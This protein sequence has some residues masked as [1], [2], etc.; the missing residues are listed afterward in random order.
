MAGIGRPGP[1]PLPDD[2]RQRANTPVSGEQTVVTPSDMPDYVDSNPK[3]PEP[4]EKWHPVARAMYDALLTDPCRMTMTSGDWALS[5]LTIEN[6][7][8]DMKPQVV[9]TIPGTVEDGI[10]IPGDVI[11]DTVAINGSR[12][13]NVLKWAA[14]VGLG[15]ANRMSMGMNI[16]MGTTTEDLHGK[17]SG[18]VKNRADLFLVPPTEGS[19]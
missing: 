16:R 9:A 2:V 13:A 15:H 10:A 1:P 18:V 7:S 4:N 11:K 5:M 19:A 17:P 14:M 12:M 6:V 8:R 3:P